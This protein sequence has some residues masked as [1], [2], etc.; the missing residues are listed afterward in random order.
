MKFV[1]NNKEIDNSLIKIRTFNFNQHWRSENVTNLDYELWLDYN[2]L[3]QYYSRRWEDNIADAKQNTDSDY[4]LDIQLITNNY[5]S[6]NS[7]L[8]QPI[9]YSQLIGL[10]IEQ[11]GHDMLLTHFDHNKESAESFYL[12]SFD[13]IEITNNFVLL[14]GKCRNNL[15]GY[16]YQDY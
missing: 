1:V 5:P 7:I 11:D 14:K 15:S 6:L 13:T 4:E 8:K 16:A 3:E 2:V 12:N 9:Y 10:L